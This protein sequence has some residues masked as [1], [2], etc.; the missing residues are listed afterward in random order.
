MHVIILQKKSN[1]KAKSVYMGT[2]FHSTDSSNTIMMVIFF[3]G[4][5]VVVFSIILVSGMSRVQALLIPATSNLIAK[6]R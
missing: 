2:I 4:S 6:R 5:L 1:I 3:K